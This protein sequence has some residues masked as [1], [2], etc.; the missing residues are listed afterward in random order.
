VV[1]TGGLVNGVKCFS[2]SPACSARTF[3]K[4]AGNL[5]GDR[6]AFTAGRAVI[7][8]FTARPA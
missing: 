3:S 8:R 7:Q 5:G 2:R 6:Q 1:E 4:K